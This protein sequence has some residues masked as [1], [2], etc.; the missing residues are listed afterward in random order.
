MAAP[1]GSGWRS[2]NTPNSTPH[3]PQPWMRQTLN[4]KPWMRQTLN[5]KPW[6]H[7]TLNPKPT[8]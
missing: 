6:M 7:Q 4:P 3:E 5:P 1:D 8:Q 2:S